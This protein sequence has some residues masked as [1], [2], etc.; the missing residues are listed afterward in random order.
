MMKMGSYQI[1]YIQK[2]GSCH[3]ADYYQPPKT[4]LFE[5]W[6][7]QSQRGSCQHDSGT[8]SQHGIIPFMGQLLDEESQN[9]TYNRGTAKPGSTNQYVCHNQ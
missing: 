8:I 4:G 2:Q 5:G 3:Y 9:G 6:H 7:Y 1:Q